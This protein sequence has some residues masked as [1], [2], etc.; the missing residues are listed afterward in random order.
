MSNIRLM[1]YDWH[2]PEKIDENNKEKF[3]V[4]WNNIGNDFCYQ[5]GYKF[6]EKKHNF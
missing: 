2:I 5:R 1:F 6:I 4:I 3:N